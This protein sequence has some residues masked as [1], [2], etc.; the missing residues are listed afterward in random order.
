M[1]AVGAKPQNAAAITSI[2]QANGAVVTQAAHGYSNGDII[3]FYGTTG[4]LQIS[5]MNFEISNVSA[6]NYT[7]IG[8]NSS[9]FASAA[10]AGFVQ[11][12]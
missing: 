12:H 10:T 1:G 5:G 7:L 9:G 4:M 11:D 3:Q 2:T 6:N 8:L